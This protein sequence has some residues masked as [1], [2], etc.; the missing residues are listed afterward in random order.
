MPEQG[1]G[2][3]FRALETATSGHFKN[4]PFASTLQSPG[5]LRTS[6]PTS[7]ALCMCQ[8]FFGACTANA[9]VTAPGDRPCL[10]L[11]QRSFPWGISSET[12]DCRSLTFSQHTLTHTAL[13]HSKG[14]TLSLLLRPPHP[15]AL[16]FWTQLLDDIASSVVQLVC[17]GVPHGRHT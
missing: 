13:T 11:L 15:L 9:A 1:V 10:C 2:D 3:R 6:C 12:S 14:Q 5:V 17:G 8:C 16:S 4:F 7:S